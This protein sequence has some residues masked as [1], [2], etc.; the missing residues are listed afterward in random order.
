MVSARLA[1]VRST[2]LGAG[3]RLAAYADLIL[4]RD[5]MLSPRRSA[6]LG[7]ASAAGLLILCLAT[8]AH[9]SLADTRA[10]AT[11]TGVVA[12]DFHLPDAADPA[13]RLFSLS[14]LRGST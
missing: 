8:I 5:R 1:A 13:G 4:W 12:P 11:R 14:D 9:R 6:Q 2:R 10:L 7:L 3:S